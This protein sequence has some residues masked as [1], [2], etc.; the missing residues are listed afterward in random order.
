LKRTILIIL[1]VFK[2]SLSLK[3][4]SLPVVDFGFSDQCNG[5]IVEFTNLSYALSGEIMVFIWDFGDGKTSNAINPMHIYEN[6][7]SY[8]VKLT[9]ID[10]QGR[11]ASNQKIIQ[12]FTSPEF[13]PPESVSVCAED[14][15]TIDPMIIFA[16]SVSW[17]VNSTLISD[18]SIL[19]HTANDSLRVFDL[20]LKASNANCSI[21]E[22]IKI[23]I[24]E[25]PDP[26][27]LISGFCENSETAIQVDIDEP[28]NYN[29]EISLNDSLVS[30][31]RYF[32]SSLKSGTDS[33]KY[34]HP[35][36]RL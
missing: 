21:S 26:H 28:Y 27:L 9:V 18:S 5:E 16:D 19:Y 20:H 10:D 13:S 2:I 8:N 23:E 15:L 7:G 1:L 17:T 29:F 24:N 32:N 35:L 31:D 25:K 6:S 36:S 4:Q 34:T 30:S 3:S 12:I 14:I 22:K 33:A 11:F